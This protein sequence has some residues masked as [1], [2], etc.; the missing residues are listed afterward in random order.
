MMGTAGQIA[1]T[2][3]PSLA[4]EAADEFNFMLPIVPQGLDDFV[5]LVAPERQRR[6]IFRTAYADTTWG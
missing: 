5:G 2:M 4:V 3:Q 1:D 6:G